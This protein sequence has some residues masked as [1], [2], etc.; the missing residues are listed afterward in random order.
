MCLCYAMMM[1]CFLVQAERKESQLSLLWSCGIDVDLG[2]GVTCQLCRGT[3]V[4]FTT[5][6][7]SAVPGYTLQRYRGTSVSCNRVYMS[8]LR[9][10]FFAAIESGLSAKSNCHYCMVGHIY[11][12]A[13]WATSILTKQL[14]T[15][16]TIFT[17][18]FLPRLKSQAVGCC[19]SPCR[20]PSGVACFYGDVGPR[21]CRALSSLSDSFFESGALMLVA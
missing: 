14:N 15:I 6:H 21:G 17:R 2:T 18:H 12:I 5:V 3:S 9:F 10:F 13:W 19:H 20:R 11:P 16:F 8:A 1:T 4:S 7:V